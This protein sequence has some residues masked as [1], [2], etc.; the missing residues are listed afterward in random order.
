VLATRRERGASSRA[1][2]PAFLAFAAASVA[3]F[4]VLMILG[5]HLWFFNDDWAYVVSR[6]EMWADGRRVDA[7]LAPHNEHWST[8]PAVVQALI[9]KVVAM[10]SYMPYLASALVAHVAVVTLL[11][12]VL[13]RSHCSP[14]AATALAAPL[15]L[16][17]AGAESL[18]FAVQFGF[19]AAVAFGLGQ[20]LL[21]DHDGPLDRRDAAGVVLAVLGLASSGT[22][23]PVV[24]ATT[25]A[26]ALHRRWRAI[27]LHTGVPAAAYVAWYAGW[28]VRADGERHLDL[29]P[30]YVFHGVTTALDGLTQWHGAGAV[31][32]LGAI[33]VAV[34]GGRAA[35]RRDALAWGCAAGGVALFAFTALDRASFG[36]EQAGSSRYV[37]VA[38]VLFLPA[39]VVAVRAALAGVAPARRTLFAVVLVAWAATANV[40]ELVTF[41]R[42]RL[43]GTDANRRVTVAA[44][45]LAGVPGVDPAGQPDDHFSAVVT[46]SVLRELVVSGDLPL[47]HVPEADLVEQ[48]NR[49]AVRFALGTAPAGVAGAGD[50]IVVTEVR[51]GAAAGDGAGCLVVEPV[52]GVVAPVVELDVPARAR[53]VVSDTSGRFELTMRT[54]SGVR[55]M[56]PTVVPIETGQALTVDVLVASRPV[57][58]LPAGTPTRLCGVRSG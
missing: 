28:G 50:G 29:V 35:A 44:A 51:N 10:H 34:I 14:W 40:A 25:V 12:L 31:I 7:L 47:P 37:Y 11:R 36:V 53:L 54:P 17:G 26:L 13:V 9:Y 5:R 15:L 8:V 42:D 43:A 55:A 45:A 24:V 1:V 52:A 18:A 46:L 20:L 16:F 49:F 19:N 21:A 56:Q 2:E 38:G 39:L 23:V 22:A 57:L 41:E 27:A 30:A 58:A 33:A 3:A 48:Q 6:R 32:A 4:V